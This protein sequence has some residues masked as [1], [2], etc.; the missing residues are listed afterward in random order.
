MR[1]KS[2]KFDNRQNMTRTTYEVFHYNEPMKNNVEV[3][4]HDFYEIFIL[5]SGNISYWMEGNIY[6]PKPGDILLIDP[7]TLH[8]PIVDQNE[9][10]YER[11]VLWINKNYLASYVEK[12][13]ELSNCFEKAV[14][15]KRRLIRPTPLQKAD[16]T[17]KLSNLIKEYYSHDYGSSLYADSIFLQVMIELNRLSSYSAKKPEKQNESSSLV[18]GLLEYIGE[19]FVEDISLDILSERFFVSKYHLSHEFSKETGTS[20]YRYIMLKR[21]SKA[22]QMLQSDFTSAETAIQ[23]GFK[24]YTSFFRAFKSEYGISPKAYSEVA[25]H[26]F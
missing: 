12:G 15:N 4:N 20:I 16:L 6:K 9:P 18:T 22:K 13:T 17:E 25:Q 19:N 7:M 5:I 10:N 21:L 1:Q 26:D 14:E 24:D 8:R 23:C 11:I 3:H 2:Q